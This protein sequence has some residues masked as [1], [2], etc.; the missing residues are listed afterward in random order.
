MVAGT[1]SRTDMEG[2]SGGIDK[3]LFG[4]SSRYCHPGVLGYNC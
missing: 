3:W 4:V 1:I 2:A